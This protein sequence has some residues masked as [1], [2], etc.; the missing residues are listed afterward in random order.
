MFVY[1]RNN[2]FSVSGA[3]MCLTNYIKKIYANQ[4]VLKLICTYFFDFKFG[5][6]DYDG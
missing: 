2:L 6:E 3:L 4:F 5:G 1:S